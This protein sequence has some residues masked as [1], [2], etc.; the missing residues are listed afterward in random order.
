MS[1][2][3]SL[4]RK[5]DQLVSPPLVKRKIQSTTSKHAV[6]S[7]FT[8]TSQ[9]PK[10]RT[11]WS[12][13]AP[14]E[15]APATLLVGRYNSQEPQQ[16][17]SKV[18]AFDL[19]STLISTASGKK[20]ADDPADWKWWDPIVP[21]KLRQLHSD[22]YH[23]V[24]FSNQGGMTLHPD[25]KSKAPKKFTAERI[26]KFKAKVNAILSALNLTS[27]TIYAAT[28]KDIFRKPRPG[29]WTAMCDDLK[30]KPEAV[31]IDASFFIGDA[32]GRTAVVKEGA[33]KAGT[34]PKD[35]SCSD[36]NFAH[37]VGIRFQ[38]PE[39]YF[40]GHQPRAFVR[41]VDL[42][43]YTFA[44]GRPKDKA[45]IFTQ[46]QEKEIVIF[47]GS[48]GAG[49][50]T[51]YW[52]HL[53]SLG[54]ARVNQDILKSK[55]RCFKAAR[56]HLDEG[57]S[58]AVDNTNADPDTRG[59]WIS[60]AGKHGVPIRCV[61]FKTPIAL[62][63]HNDA[64]RGLNSHLNPESRE[65]LPKLAFNGF[66]SRFKEP[67]LVEGFK[68]I[69]E[70]DFSF[71][72]T[73]EEHKTF[74]RFAYLLYD[75]RFLIWIHC[76]GQSSPL[77][78]RAHRVRVYM[79]EPPTPSS[80]EESSSYSLYNEQR[81]QNLDYEKVHFEGGEL[82]DK[83][84]YSAD[85]SG[86]CVFINALRDVV[87]LEGRLLLATRIFRGFCDSPSTG[88]VSGYGDEE[89]DALGRDVQPLDGDEAKAERYGNTMK[90]V[91]MAV[92]KRTEQ[93]GELVQKRARASC[94]RT[95][96][97]PSPGIQATGLPTNLCYIT[98]NGDEEGIDKAVSEPTAPG[99][100]CRPCPWPEFLLEFPDLPK[101]W[102]S[103]D[104]PSLVGVGNNTRFREAEDLLIHSPS[105]TAS[106]H[107][108]S[109][110]TTR[111][112]VATFSPPPL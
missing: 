56:E 110:W 23:I 45:D 11:V 102:L 37:N 18:A 43:K 26:P 87:V 75:I 41:D 60:L 79:F 103:V 73:E 104:M 69:V 101:I 55:D 3:S 97:R 48:P 29:M 88:T 57:D 19:D 81:P 93:E 105:T 44:G 34:I 54:Y 62:C 25:P 76:A 38:T 7:F 99:L 22:G 16:S 77:S 65:I 46:G 17:N 111:P 24:I 9:K 13:R 10:S 85:N 1:S 4:K 2:S 40:H 72:G 30:T 68:E 106:G 49:K 27:V 36:R 71:N 80:R 91:G 28:G 78:P 86:A 8:P 51:F 92:W 53:E 33:K 12:E 70:I 14:N 52:K 109:A 35:F 59:Q 42:E 90:A 96:W 95:I 98:M 61:W 67:K 63:E 50:S 74:A 66:A 20:H 6:A 107:S 84:S 108:S 100:K 5:A 83:I 82:P 15:G 21:T 112:P 39:E 31:Q 89:W 32:G 47:C 64:V 94:L 58:V